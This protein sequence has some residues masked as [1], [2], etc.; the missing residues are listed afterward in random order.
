MI[1]LKSWQN[2]WSEKYNVFT[3][4]VNKIA[5]KANNNQKILSIVSKEMHRYGMNKDLICEKEETRCNTI[6]QQP[7]SDWC[8][9]RKH[10]RT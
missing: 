1:L 8:Y 3:E 10:T 7:K 5:L 2:F 9:K 4:E 6:I